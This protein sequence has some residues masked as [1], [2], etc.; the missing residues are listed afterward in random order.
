MVFLKTLFYNFLI[1]FFANHILPGIEVVNQTKLPHIG[2]DLIFAAALGLLDSLIY[3]ALKLLKQEPTYFR[4]GLIAVILNFI[5]YAILRFLPIGVKVMSLEGY[6]I[7]SLVVT[8]GAFL[9][10][11]FEMRHY[12]SSGMNPG[13]Q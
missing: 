13:P 7:A 6:L 9:T 8:V 10:N 4:I 11:F 3:P 12:Q 1:V 5:A 2:G